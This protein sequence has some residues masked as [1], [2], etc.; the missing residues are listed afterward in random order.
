MKKIFSNILKMSLCAVL[1]TFVAGCDIEQFEVK[2]SLPKGVGL[3]QLN[4]N[5]SDSARTSFPA[6]TGVTY[7]I[8][9]TPQPS[10]DPIEFDSLSKEMAAGT[11]N[12]TIE[13]QIGTATKVT[14]AVAALTNVVVTSRQTTTVPVLL[15]PKSGADG[16]LSWKIDV[17]DVSLLTKYE[18]EY[19]SSTDFADVD[20]EWTKLE[21]FEEGTEGLPPGSYLL[22][23]YVEGEGSRSLGDIEAFHIYSGLTTSVAF[24]YPGELLFNLKPAVVEVTFNTTAVITAVSVLLG[25]DVMDEHSHD[26]VKDT[27]NPNK[28]TL[29]TEIPDVNSKFE[30]T[31]YITTA[32]NAVPLEF[33]FVDVPS[34]ADTTPVDLV[35]GGITIYSVTA[36]ITGTGTLSVN[37]VELE[38]G[39]KLDV[40]AGTEV[41]LAPIEPIADWQFDMED[42]NSLKVDGASFDYTSG[43]V[44]V[45]KDLTIEVLFKNVPGYKPPVIF[46]W[47]QGTQPWEALLQDHNAVI[48]KVTNFPEI[49]VV[50]YGGNNAPAAASGGI[51]LSNVRLVIGQTLGNTG[52]AAT[53]GVTAATDTFLTNR[54]GQLDLSSRKFKATINYKDWTSNGTWLRFAI[55]NNGTGHAVS[56]FNG[57]APRESFFAQVTNAAFPNSV[58]TSGAGR[59]YYFT[60]GSNATSGTLV[61]EVDPIAAYSDFDQYPILQKTFF[62]IAA[63]TGAITITGIRLEYTE[64]ESA[65]GPVTKANIYGP[66]AE[67]IT[68]TTLRYVESDQAHHIALTAKKIPASAEGTFTWSATSANGI[69]VGQDGVVHIAA[70]TALGTSEIKAVTG[71]IEAKIAIEIYSSAPTAIDISGGAAAGKP[72]VTG[73]KGSRTLEIDLAGETEV[74]RQLTATVLP[75]GAE[76]TV[77]WLTD[78]ISIVAVDSVT[79]LITAKGVLPDAAEQTATITARI[80][81][82]HNI[83][84]T[85]VVTVKNVTPS[86]ELDPNIIFEWTVAD[87]EPAGM[88]WN[89]GSTGTASVSTAKLSGKGIMTEM[90]ISLASAASNTDIT[91]NNGIVYGSA[92][93]ARSLLIGSGVGRSVVSTASETPDGVLDFSTL[94]AGKLGIKFTVTVS[95]FS[96]TPA[97]GNLS[98]MINNN[99]AGGANTPLVPAGN[100]ANGS[101]ILFM[102]NGAIATADANSDGDNDNGYMNITSGS[103]TLVCRT[104]KPSDISSGQGTLA[105]AFIALQHNGVAG[106][107]FKIVGI[108]IEYV[109]AA[110]VVDTKTIWQWNF[111]DDKARLTTGALAGAA[112][113]TGVNGGAGLVIGT[114][115]AQLPIFAG[116]GVTVETN[117]I[118]ITDTGT[119]FQSL[120]IGAN[121]NTPS[122]SSSADSGVFDFRTGNTNGIRVIIEADATWAGRNFHVSLCN[123]TSGAANTPIGASNSARIVYASNAVPSGGNNGTWTA[124][125][126]PAGTLVSRTFTAAMYTGLTGTGENSLNYLDKAWL[127]M[128]IGGGTVGT[129]V[130]ILIK[131]ITIEYIPAP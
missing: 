10:G 43:A 3:V 70:D 5:G 99:S 36:N 86:G 112:Y 66:T 8:T 123:N 40:L 9:A 47:S 120:I 41:L 68:G 114:N 48:G 76:G 117:G 18:L 87:G 44:T 75:A 95:D 122:T 128:V 108:K 28:W 84:D 94:P 27:A 107:S 11:Y 39:K 57:T 96:A 37:N 129:G 131:S 103:G 116:A 35:P 59:S 72:G 26:M 25:G 53:G 51:Q 49:G 82:H 125:V 55:H 81:E 119:S 88:V 19:I 60:A 90:P 15:I 63:Q 21:P 121:T 97:A 101:R 38:N 62:A 12:F 105:K 79:G 65:I 29:T 74:T 110:A 113:L 78:N 127:G 42:A 4:I 58:T 130:T 77:E 106:V 46:A 102:Q 2:N 83:S 104:F 14:V 93:P 34:A 64:M 30:G 45:S 33:D 109:P 124:G 17:P 69:T 1:L 23:T 98:F 91:W 73:E 20:G 89:S 54:G 32:N 71:L 111:E 115:A 22:K 13:A 92:A 16:T 52:G 126:A 61:I 31:L 67:L 118:K 56:P 50:V 100:V 7:K 24:H 6:L 80:A 85:V